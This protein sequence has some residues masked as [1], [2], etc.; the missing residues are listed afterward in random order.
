MRKRTPK[1]VVMTSI[2]GEIKELRRI[3]ALFEITFC[4]C[5]QQVCRCQPF[6]I[7]LPKAH[8]EVENSLWKTG[9]TVVKLPIWLLDREINK[10]RSLG[11]K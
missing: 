2:E 6:K 3:S 5:F 10:H 1:P 11:L 4:K 9:A 8:C 7:W